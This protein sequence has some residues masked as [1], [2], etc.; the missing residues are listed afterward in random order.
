MTPQIFTPPTISFVLKLG[1]TRQA[2]L[3]H[4]LRQNATCI[5]SRFSEWE[6]TRQVSAHK[7]LL[8]AAAE[9]FS[10]DPSLL[11]HHYCSTALWCS[12]GYDQWVGRSIFNLK[13]H[14]YIARDLWAP[15]NKVSHF[16]PL[17]EQWSIKKTIGDHPG[18]NATEIYSSLVLSDA[19]TV[20]QHNWFKGLSTASFTSGNKFS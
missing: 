6:A 15:R 19:V 10:S 3:I 14:D 9:L 8:L 16:Q 17:G 13:E 5:G 20:E 12:D 1:F 7:T 4:L 11:G 2:F 18:N